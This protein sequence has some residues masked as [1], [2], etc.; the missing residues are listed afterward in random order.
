[1]PYLWDLKTDQHTALRSAISHALSLQTTS[2]ISLWPTQ[3]LQDFQN[4]DLSEKEIKILNI[5]IGDVMKQIL[6]LGGKLTFHGQVVDT[7]YYFTPEQGRKLQESIRIRSKNEQ[8]YLTIK[9]KNVSKTIKDRQERE[10]HLPTPKDYED[11]FLAMGLLPLYTREKI[12]FSYSIDDMTFDIDLYA[13]IPPMLEIEGATEE[14]IRTWIAKLG[15]EHK[16]IVNWTARKTLEYY[17][18]KAGTTKKT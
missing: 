11:L 15:L 7:Y 2:T 16:K 10:I 13:G 3:F 8:F 14:H 18:K 6:A 1:M 5:S 4:I 12:R 17:K 9:Q